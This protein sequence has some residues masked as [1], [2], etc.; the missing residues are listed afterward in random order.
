MPRP[1]TLREAHDPGF[2]TENYETFHVCDC[3]G[4]KGTKT[5][6]TR[7]KTLRTNP[8]KKILK[9][10]ERYLLDKTGEIHDRY[11]ALALVEEK[12]GTEIALKLAKMY[13]IETDL[14]APVIV[15]PRRLK[16]MQENPL[17]GTDAWV[18]N[19]SLKIRHR[20]ICRRLL[21]L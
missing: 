21:M 16:K 8:E 6:D 4:A 14:D 18:I 15:N 11:I 1:A 2:I 19:F 3:E 12:Y 9:E 20:R 10:A 17:A 7:E 5:A 13:R